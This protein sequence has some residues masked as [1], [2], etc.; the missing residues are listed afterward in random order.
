[1]SITELGWTRILRRIFG[2]KK[3]AEENSTGIK[4]S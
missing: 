4:G 1:V 2:P 3:E